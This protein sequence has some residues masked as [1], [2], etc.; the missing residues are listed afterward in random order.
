MTTA[1]HRTDQGGTSQGLFEDPERVARGLGWF[2]IGLG[3]AEL[4]APRS[5]ARMIGVNDDDDN[6]NTLFALGLREIASGV[7][8]LARPRSALPMWNRVGGDMMDLAPAGPRA[9]LRLERAQPGGGGDGRRHR[10]DRPRRAHRPEIARRHRQRRRREAPRRHPRDPGDHAHPPARGSLL[11]LAR[12]REP[13]PLH[14]APRV[15]PGAGA[16][17]P[18]EGPRP[19][20]DDGGVGCRDHRRPAERAHRLAL[21]AG[22]DVSNIGSVRFLDAPGGRHR[23][24]GRAPLRP[25]RRQMAAHRQALRRGALPAA[26]ERPP[27]VQAGHGAR[28]SRPVRRHPH[29]GPHPARPPELDEIRTLRA[30]SSR[31][32]GR[33]HRDESRLLDGQEERP[34]RGSPRSQD[35]QHAGRDPAGHVDGHLRLRPAPVQRFRARHGAGR[36]PGPRVHGRGRGSRAGVRNLKT[37]DR[38]VVPF[39]IACGDAAPCAGRTSSRSARTP[40]RTAGWRRSSGALARRASSATR[41]CSAGSRADRRSTSACPSP[42]WDRIKVPDGMPDEQALFLSDIFPTGY[43]GAEMCNIKPGDVIAV[44]GAGPVGHFAMASAYL[45]GAE[46][47]IAID[48]FPYRLQ[49]AAGA[50]PARGD[51][52][53]RGGPASSS[54]STS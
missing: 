29:P 34:G 35:P 12:L 9:A 28:R 30:S 32:P 33:S 53:L 45:L 39:P 21:A 36:R 20:R 18:L 27:P 6:R 31:K 11:L 25:T 49:M 44:W 37:G 26:L 17:A 5:L 19:G 48:R 43:M 8:V 22:A 23:G 4:G 38:V 40:T 16:G 14:G 47:V 7:A 42:T 15:G 13:A 10:R 1:T 2:S 50:R 51:D 3:L 24:A 52:Q 54:A 41:I 46:R